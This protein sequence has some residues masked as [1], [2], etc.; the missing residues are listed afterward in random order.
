M[1]DGQ[2]WIQNEM[3]DDSEVFLAGLVHLVSLNFPA[4]LAVNG[5]RVHSALHGCHVTQQQW[6]PPEHLSSDSRLLCVFYVYS[7]FIVHT[8]L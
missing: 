5:Q 2:K 1:N 7:D 6:T 8:P 4:A 3:C